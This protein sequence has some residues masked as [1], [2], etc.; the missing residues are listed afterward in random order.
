VFDDRLTPVRAIGF[1]QPVA[2]R[3]S[4]TGWKV[5]PPPRQLSKVATIKDVAETAQVSRATVSR[6]F[7]Q[8]H[9]VNRETVA[10]VQAVARRLS[11]V[12]NH[13]ARALSTGRA[14]NIA[15][16][17]PDITNVFFA[18]LMRGA[19][20]TARERGYA[21]FLG[22]SDEAPEIEDVLL[23]KLAA[24]VDGFVLAS[25]RLPKERIF[26]HAK[27]R[28][29]VLVNRDIPGLSRLLVDT[30]TTYERAVKYLADLGHRAVAYVAGPRLS[31][32]NRQRHA[33]VA[34]AAERLGLRLVKVPT[35]RPSF[36]AGR[37][38][39]DSLIAANVTAALAYDD[40]I[41]QGIITGLAERG[42]SVP[43]DISVVGCDGVLAPTISPPLT[44]V[45]IPCATA[46][47]LAVELLLDMLSGPARRVQSIRLQTELMIRATTTP[48]K[49]QGRRPR[50]QSPALP[51]VARPGKAP[52]REQ[53]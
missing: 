20:A 16:V 47:K 17:L 50:V 37:G 32:S 22:D 27:R 12:P 41:A 13:T 3:K 46:G 4:R 8:P 5:A 48:P 36:E 53:R 2:G 6:V 52:T 10:L 44:S 51:A 34:T 33:A 9:L 42:Y 39:A 28:P 31:W 24:Q 45:E 43:D 1:M 26:E 40:I 19:Q 7:S 25:S 30:A 49:G 11:Y 21:T 15:L 23:A 18:A 14:G 29:L 35:A 38:C